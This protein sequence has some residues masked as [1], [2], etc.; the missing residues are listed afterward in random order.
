ME[1]VQP[2]PIPASDIYVNIGASWVDSA[3]YCDFLGEKLGIPRYY[4]KGLKITF[5][6]YDGSW[7]VE[8][9][10]DVR[11]Y[12]GIKATEVYG[13]HRANAFRIFE[14]CLNQRDTT[15]CDTV[16]TADGQKKYVVNQSETLSARE[17]QHKMQ[18][19]FRDWIFSTPER[20]EDLERTYNRL[21][22]QI[23]LP[24]FDGSYL[25]FPNMNPYIQLYP[26]Q[27]NA[28]QRILTNGSTLDPHRVGY[29]K[30]FTI[31]AAIMKLRQYG[32]AK[33]PM[34]VVPNH[35]I[36][37]WSGEFRQLYANA[38]LLIAEKEDLEQSRRK[39]FVSKAAMGDWDAIIIAQSAFAKIPV[40][41]ERQRRKI[42]QEIEDIE[43]SIRDR[44]E[45]YDHTSVKNLERIKKS[46]EAALKRLM[47]DKTKDTVV[48]CDLATPKQT[49]ESYECGKNFDAYNELK[50]KLIE[51]GIP[52]EQ[53]AYI[54]E[55]KKDNEKLNLFNKVKGNVL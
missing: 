53:I 21:F 51:K 20:R 26:H 29:G 55:A 13:T 6:R 37:Q 17:R 27:V 50:C 32:L 8:R 23:R 38:K 34:I 1:A 41:K 36:G 18:D 3:Y 15:I 49:F 16:Q 46:R 7:E 44:K 14:D 5:N 35:L 11:K 4:L 19:E 42:E 9:S 22:N 10:D 43:N 45:K 24:K 30:T 31:V 47:D 40:S 2:T 54:H 52:Q 39:I 25:K 33:K 12:A 28:V 48:F